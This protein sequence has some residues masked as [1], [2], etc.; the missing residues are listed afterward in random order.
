VTQQGTILLLAVLLAKV[1]TGCGKS[2]LPMV[3]VSG[4]ITF[5][6]APPPAAGSIAFNPIS[7]QNGLPRRPGTAQFGTDGVF[8]V[9]SFKQNDGLLPGKYSARI[10][11]WKGNPATSSDPNAFERLNFVPKD[12]QP[13]LVAIE[14]GSGAV[15]VNIDVPKK[16]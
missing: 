6:G 5:V 4:K 14:A 3:P 13:A 10:E 15:E 11:C 16:N 7:A 1:C 8:R 2:G 9:T 12:F